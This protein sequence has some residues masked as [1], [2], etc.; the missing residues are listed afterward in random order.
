MKEIVLVAGARPNFMKIGPIMHALSG[1][2]TLSSFLVH[3][4]QHYDKAMSE[5]FFTELNIPEPDLNL[6]VGGGTH[7]AMTAQV[8]EKMEALLMERRP[9]V[10]LVV[11]DVNST[12]A[13]ALAAAKLC[14][15]VAHV[16]AGLR[17]FDREMPEEINR[18]LTDRISDWL[19]T[20]EPEGD[21]NLIR[22][23]VDRARIFRVGN[24]MID[25]LR[26]NLEKAQS[27]RTLNKLGLASG[28]YGLVTL[29]RPSNVDDPAQLRALFDVLDEIHG[30]LPLLFP[31][32]PRTRNAV[33]EK[34]GGHKPALRV[35]DPLGYHDFLAVMADAKLVLT[36]SGGVQEETTALGVPC[37]TLRENTE[38]P[39][40]VTHGTNVIAGRDPET[41]R[42][43]ARKVLDG[44]G[45]AGRIPEL[46]DG[47]TAPRV[48]E[49]LAAELA[50]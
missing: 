37:I 49:I 30:E 8:L 23:G 12:I 26:A 39:V 32:H 21:A 10:V 35:V 27:R 41:I 46:W 29:H 7:G 1:H 28:E 44:S 22:E 19:F 20:T 13:A 50:K 31:M 5:Q 9:A 14:I 4:G 34:M 43:E 45:K 2:P 47:K 18:V 11:G 42:A 15:P 33:S 16:E 36:D 25:S 3:T 24:V 6:G 38:R 40:T 48:V 17:S